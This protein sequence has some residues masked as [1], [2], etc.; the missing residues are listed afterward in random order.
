MLEH[1]TMAQTKLEGK[2]K[3]LR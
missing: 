2:I 1:G 3:K